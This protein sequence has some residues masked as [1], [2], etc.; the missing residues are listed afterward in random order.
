MLYDF[1]KQIG[2]TIKHD[3]HNS[4]YS[5][6]EDIDSILIDGEYRKRFQVDNHWFYQNP[7]YIIEGIGSVKNGLLGHITMIPTGGYFFWE[8]I[9]FKENGIVKYLN[10]SY[11]DCFPRNFFTSTNQFSLDSDI[12]LYQNP[13]D[14][15]LIIE[16][17]SNRRNL[18][19]KIFDVNGRIL[20]ERQLPA[21]KSEIDF[22]YNSG[23][24]CILIVDKKGQI[25]MSKKILKQ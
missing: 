5:T 12:I 16:N 7:D 10:P 13:I 22:S 24:Y 20:I 3:S 2:D 11:N 25:T 14:E 19:L 4:F 23:I 6:I 9:C 17:N 1:S 21:D 15:E 8:H 18:T